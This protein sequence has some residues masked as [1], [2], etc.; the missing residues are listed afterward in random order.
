MLEMISVLNV[1]R[2]I[3]WPSMLSVLKN[4]PCA[5]TSKECVLRYLGWDVLCILSPSSVMCHLRPVFPY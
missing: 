1:L 4:V 3:L 5:V 2:L